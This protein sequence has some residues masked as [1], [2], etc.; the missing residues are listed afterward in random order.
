MFTRSNNRL[1]RARRLYVRLCMNAVLE[2]TDDSVL[3]HMGKRMAACGLYAA[4]SIQN[5][6]DMRYRIVRIIFNLQR[7]SFGATQLGEWSFWCI[8]NGF[9]PTSFR[10][11]KK[12]IA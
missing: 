3:D 7:G 8:R 2:S 4:A 11:N 10:R 5:K 6:H 9:S 1:K 12:A